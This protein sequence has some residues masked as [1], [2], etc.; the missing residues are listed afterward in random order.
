[1]GYGNDHYHNEYA[2]TRHDHRGQYADDRH[3]HSLDY[4]EKHHRHYDDERTVA[5]VREDLGRAEGRIYDLER[6]LGSVRA[7]LADFRQRAGANLASLNELVT[8]LTAEVAKD[9]D[10]TAMTVGVLRALTFNLGWQFRGETRPGDWDPDVEFHRLVGETEADKPGPAVSARTVQANP[11]TVEAAELAVP[12]TGLANPTHFVQYAVRTPDRVQVYGD[13]SWVKSGTAAAGHPDGGADTVARD[14]WVSYGPWRTYETGETEADKPAPIPFAEEPAWYDPDSPDPQ[15]CPGCR[16]R[17]HCD[18]ATSFCE[19]PCTEASPVETEA[20]KPVQAD[21]P[22]RPFTPWELA[23]GAIGLFLEYRDA[24]GQDEEDAR[25]SAA[26]EVAQGAA[27]TSDDLASGEPEAPEAPEFDLGPEV[28]DV[29]GMSE[30]RY[31][32]TEEDR[33]RG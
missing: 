25:R 19:C 21:P 20:D 28:D 22:L 23:D 3:D 12:G 27:V 18:G 30:H 33:E 14:I 4:A 26:L 5:G 31:L 2:D 32:I 1:M 29:G 8:E 15:F 11:V 9:P 24:H 10:F 6:E 13:Q 7:E 17:Q 16:A